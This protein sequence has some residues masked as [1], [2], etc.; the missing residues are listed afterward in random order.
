MNESGSAWS[1]SRTSPE[2][3]PLIDATP[4]MTVAR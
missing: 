4:A 1:D 3:V 2:Y